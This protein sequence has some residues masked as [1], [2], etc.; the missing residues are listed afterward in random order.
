M[1]SLASLANKRL[2][3][4]NLA[5]VSEGMF[6]VEEEIPNWLLRFNPDL[7]PQTSFLLADVFLF[8]DTFLEE[9]KQTLLTDPEAIVQSG[10]WSER[11]SSG[12]ERHL[13]ASA[14]LN[15]HQLLIQIQLIDESR[16]YHQEVFQQAREYSLAFEKVAKERERKEVLLH[17]IVHDLAGPLT[18]IFGALE[19]LRGDSTRIDLIEIALRQAGLQKRMIQ[20]ILETFSAEFKAFDP[21]LLRYETAPRLRQILKDQRDSFKAAFESKHVKLE[22]ID[23]AED[24]DDLPVIAE[25]DYLERVLS[26]LLENSLR[27]SPEGSTTS[28]RLSKDQDHY[29]IA[30]CDQGNGV[31]DEIKAHMFELFSGGA[32]FEGKLGLGLYFCRIAL[33]RWG[34]TI[35]CE[36]PSRESP[37]GPGTCM[38]FTLKP[39]PLSDG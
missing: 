19:L 20:S 3:I 34:Q 16:R 39:L 24:K 15:E 26:N 6:L 29:L 23:D 2:N 30:V 14:F 5:E 38:V 33:E 28:I 10:P 36:S 1:S 4:V 12:I 35:W 9:L 17:M 21:A 11:D 31:P 8:F 18:S 37:A 22:F 25:I 13:S 7:Q 27:F 32:D